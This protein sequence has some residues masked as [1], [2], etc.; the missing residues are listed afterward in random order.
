MK[1]RRIREIVCCLLLGVVGLA[2]LG[3]DCGQEEVG[4]LILTQSSITPTFVRTPVESLPATG[5]GPPFQMSSSSTA[6]SVTTTST[7]VPLFSS[8]HD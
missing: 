4:T 5:V 7:V 3:A 8:R 2:V 1:T 6:S